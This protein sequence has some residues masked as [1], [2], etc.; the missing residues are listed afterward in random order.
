[1]GGAGADFA[2]IVLLSLLKITEFE[3]KI[4]QKA[5]FLSPHVPVNMI[6]SMNSF[7][8]FERIMFPCPPVRPRPP[9]EPISGSVTPQR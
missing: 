9:P 7:N 4:S 2:T 6:F 1:M 8:L 5:G 3:L